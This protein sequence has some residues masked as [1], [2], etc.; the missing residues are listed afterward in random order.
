ML[1]LAA[2]TL[3]SG[4]IS[5][6]LKSVA[7]EGPGVVETANRWDG[8]YVG[9]FGGAT[10]GAA[11]IDGTVYN[12]GPG[13]VLPGGLADIA[14][15]LADFTFSEAAGTYGVQA[16]Y[17]VQ[18]DGVV[19]GLQAD[20]GRVGLSGSA[21]AEYITL[22]TS[23]FVTDSFE[24]NWM[25]AL[26]PRIGVLATDNLM[27]YATAGAALAKVTFN[28]DFAAYSGFLL[29]DAYL[30]DFSETQTRLG[31]VAGAGIEYALDDNWSVGAEYTYTDLGS[32]SVS[33]PIT[34]FPALGSGELIDT[35]FQNEFKLSAHALRMSVNYRF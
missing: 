31:W 24:T 3:A 6:E 12:D 23:V 22:S 13:T 35:Q 15:T 9:L 19:L 20:L 7:A 18:L 17:N 30:E 10:S 27:L 11:A 28:H 29:V 2:S 14:N 8:F 4:A 25:L 1:C 21:A 32:M 26:K 34:Y 33:N 16:G 5:G